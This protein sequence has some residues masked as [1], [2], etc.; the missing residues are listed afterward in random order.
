MESEEVKGGKT[1][2]ELLAEKEDLE[3]KLRELEKKIKK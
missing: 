1:N 3:A 2:E